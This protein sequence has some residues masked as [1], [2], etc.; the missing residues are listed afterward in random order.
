MQ[1]KV[2]RPRF[3]QKTFLLANIKFEVILKMLFL[4]I[5]NLGMLFSKKTLIWKSYINTKTPSTIK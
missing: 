3:F 1:D 2:D 5:S 4:K